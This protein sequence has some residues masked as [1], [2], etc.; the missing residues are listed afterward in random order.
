MINSAIL[1][2]SSQI[3]TKDEG[4][5]IE[6][7][8]YRASRQIPVIHEPMVNTPQPEATVSKQ[9]AVFKGST[10][11]RTLA[12]APT[13][14]LT[15][16][17]ILN[18]CAVSDAARE[19][20]AL[21][22]GGMPSHD[23]SSN[24]PRARFPE[25]GGDYD[26]LY[27]PSEP[28]TMKETQ[29]GSLNGRGKKGRRAHTGASARRSNNLPHPHSSQTSLNLDYPMKE[30]TLH[31]PTCHPSSDTSRLSLDPLHPH[32]LNLT[33]QQAYFANARANTH[34]GNAQIL[35]TGSFG[36]ARVGEMEGS[37]QAVYKVH[38]VNLSLSEGVMT[39]IL[40]T[41]S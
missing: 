14:P 4:I 27:A 26:P 15:T 20:E 9:P 29:G 19:V 5:D 16:G 24:D 30:V 6:A 37:G 10:V 38:A 36:D 28:A 13:G 33:L 40:K 34:P 32:A 21:R 8:I 11:R 17:D 25:G 18:E 3:D 2:P 39:E 12:G 23:P 31:L 22:I 35:Q 41:N 7:A 1:E